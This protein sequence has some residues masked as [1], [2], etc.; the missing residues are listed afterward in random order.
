MT[1]D[2]KY[3][4][5]VLGDYM[6]RDF[7]GVFLSAI[8]AGIMI[9]IGGSV[10]LALAASGNKLAGALL[11]SVGLFTIIIFKLYLFTGKVGYLFITDESI[12]TKAGNIIMTLL[13][14]FVGTFL[15]G[16][17]FSERFISNTDIL[18]M[19]TDKLS[20]SYIDAFLLAIPCGILM[21]VAVEGYK[22]VQDGT[23][24]AVIVAFCVAVF[25]LSG[26][27]HSIADMFYFAAARAVNL[28][29][30]MFLLIIILGN[31]VGGAGFAT[32]EGYIAKRS[33]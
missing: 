16:S 10:Y 22:R 24:K 8:L 11:F 5:M 14:N 6:K 18:R 27:E 15:M 17:A 30:I 33:K 31:A 19:V 21:F 12:G 25:I 20:L 26:F 9:G 13:G 7:W 4:K 23:V 1:G 32:L 29:S 3:I 28:K 2:E